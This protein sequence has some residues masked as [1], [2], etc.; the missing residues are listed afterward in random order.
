MSH[1]E[2]D[3][4]NPP[5][6]DATANLARYGAVPVVTID[7]AYEHV[8]MLEASAPSPPQFQDI[9]FGVLFWIHAAVMLWLGLSVAPRGYED[10]N[11]DL[12][13]IEDE[14]RKGGNDVKEEDF[15]K[16]HEFLNRATEYMQIYPVRIVHYLIVP[17]CCV[18]FG[19]A[20]VTTF[21]ILQPFPRTVV[22][23]CLIGSFATSAVLFITS[24]LASN[25]FFLS[26]MMFVM[27]VAVIYYVRLAWRMA[28]F[29]AVNLKIALVGMSQNW[30]IYVV[31][32]IITELGFFWLVFWFYTVVGVSSYETQKCQA[33]HPGADFDDI[34]ADDYDDT[35]DTSSLAFL[36]FLL[37]LYWT[38]TV[39]MV[40]GAFANK[41]PSCFLPNSLFC[42]EHNPSDSS[43]S[44]GNLVF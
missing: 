30:G 8:S 35:C 16:F 11:F 34:T 4:T 40:S 9:Y 12:A 32:C 39:I 28:P 33:A 42:L 15:Q 41:E 5:L 29:A 14:I 17:S 19:I 13:S 10:M 3:G 1:K 25:S 43:W 20:L 18:A 37:S 24:A 38:S 23:G 22:Y 44:Y 27:M 6:V 7:A 36:L 2:E 21:F 31:A 26:F